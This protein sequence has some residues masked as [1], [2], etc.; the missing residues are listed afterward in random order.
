M[1][2]FWV[3]KLEYHT[4]VFALQTF[5]CLNG[6]PFIIH[7]STWV[8]HKHA[9]QIIKSINRLSQTMVNKSEGGVFV[10]SCRISPRNKSIISNATGSLIMILGR[11]RIIV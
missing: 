3:D 10:L 7:Y 8:L 6:P 4:K 2:F 1:R 11:C 5:K 9:K